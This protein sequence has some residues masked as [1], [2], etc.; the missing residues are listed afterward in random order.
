MNQRGFMYRRPYRLINALGVIG[1]AAFT[2]CDGG[3]PIAP[4]QPS[5]VAA[6]VYV[7]GTGQT[8]TVGT[9]LAQDF[10][11]RVD[12]QAGSPVAGATV[13]WSVTG[14]G[15]S[16]APTS[17]LTDANGLSQARLTLGSTAG[18]N[19]AQATIQGLTPV[20]FTATGSSDGG[21]GPPPSGPV[22]FRTID[23]GSYHACAITTS[24]LPYCWGFNQDGE[25]GNGG[26]TLEMA[27]S[28]VEG[29]LNFRQV[30][31]GK[32]HSCAVTLSGDGYCWG[33]N[34][35]GQLGQEAGVFS[36]IPVLNGKAI[37]FGSISVGREHSCG[38][39]LT[40][41]A[42]CWGSNSA[43]QLG[44][45]TKS[46]SVDTAGSVRVGERFTRI[47]AGGLH[48][49]ALTNAPSG[50]GLPAGSAMCWGLN[51]RGQLGTGDD[52][53]FSPD[54]TG[55]SSVTLV[56]GGFTYDSITAGYEHTCALT[57]AGVALC[58]G[59]NRYGQ[60]GDGT[61]TTKL[62]P[63]PVSGGLTFVALSAGFYHTCGIT[64]T[65]AAYCWGRNT[66]T[67]LQESV[68]GQLG[69]GTTTNRSLPTA[70]AGA[71]TFRS[72]SAGEVTTCGV[73]TGSVAYCWGDNEYGQLGTGDLVAALEPV[74][75]ANQP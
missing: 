6:L 39:A 58:W 42:F 2:G 16:I 21:G 43:G 37:T 7:S 5:G 10:V 61:I 17:D 54:T 13:T 19:T 24:E 41:A 69:D 60:L 53:T 59:D 66:P 23:A 49:C 63:T 52:I 46:F 15:G 62:T 32:Y 29:G 64:N 65:S 4:E 70:V 67:S 33:S 18:A 34:V 75:V 55:P 74:R 40:G 1:F 44:F 35:V 38:L 51:D 73:T 48:N 72:I 27:P 30:S 31:G 56:A 14:G 22:V 68:G 3:D 47:A 45:L 71:L 11:V 57:A 20:S 12:D 8:G 50:S 26:T 28:A 25:L 9:A 36:A